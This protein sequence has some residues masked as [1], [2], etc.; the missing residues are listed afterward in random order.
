[1]PEHSFFT[2][3]IQTRAMKHQDFHDHG[4][5]S[6]AEFGKVRQVHNTH[7]WML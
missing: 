1:M 4:L 7:L 5:T 3:E 2:Q 6:A